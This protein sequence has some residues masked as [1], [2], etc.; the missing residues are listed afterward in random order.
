MFRCFRAPSWACRAVGAS[1][2]MH[3]SGDLTAR[4]AAG[5]GA[6]PVVLVRHLQ[7]HRMMMPQDRSAGRTIVVNHRSVSR[8]WWE[9]RTVLDESNVRDQFM[10]QQRFESRGDRRRRERREWEW[11][12]VRRH[13]AEQ[14]R[15][16]EA[17]NERY[18]VALQNYVDI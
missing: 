18:Q 1:A 6:V 4:G 14:I 16:A 17:Y 8:A 2:G 15:A 7:A 10:R 3:A 9:L 12:L 11:R 13:I 5:T